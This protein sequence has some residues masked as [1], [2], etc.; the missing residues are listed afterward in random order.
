L[1]PPSTSPYFTG[2]PTR[3]TASTFQPF[4]P[5]Y[6]S[7]TNRAKTAATVKQ[8]NNITPANNTPRNTTAVSQLARRFD[9]GKSS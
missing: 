8:S 2:T 3:I 5:R 7:P 9:S 1:P 4:N 6:R